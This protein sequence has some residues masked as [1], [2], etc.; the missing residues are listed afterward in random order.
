V[1]RT[2]RLTIETRQVC[3]IRRRQASHRAMCKACGEAVNL[4]TAD[5][6]AALA[7][8]SLRAIYRLIEA[9]KLHFTETSQEPLLI[10]F[11]S[12][13]GTDLRSI[14][15]ILNWQGENHESRK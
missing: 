12:L 9:G 11:N 10:C 13:C 15:D 6:A 14:R 8:I 3:V 5:E 1:K 2:T 7:H 4:V